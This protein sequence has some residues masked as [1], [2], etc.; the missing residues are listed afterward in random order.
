MRITLK[1]KNGG[2]VRTAEIPPFALPPEIIMWGARMFVRDAAQ[3][4]DAD[5][6]VEYLEGLMYPLIDGV[7]TTSADSMMKGGK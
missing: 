1:T 7:T 2:F 3:L 5:A 6:P 4:G